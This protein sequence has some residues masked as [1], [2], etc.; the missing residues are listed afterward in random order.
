MWASPPF[1]RTRRAASSRPVRER[2]TSA[3]SAPSAAMSAAQSRPMPLLAPVIRT[4]RPLRSV[5]GP[6]YPGPEGANASGVLLGAIAQTR[7][8]VVALLKDRDRRI[9]AGH[10]ENPADLLLGSAEGEQS[11][12]LGDT[13]AA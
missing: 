8:R 5:I 9:D 2:A 10:L 3:T 1:S 12:H 13:I 11:T 4:R 7:D 6:G